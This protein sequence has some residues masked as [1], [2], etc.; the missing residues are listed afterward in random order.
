MGRVSRTDLTKLHAENEG[1]FR[2]SDCFFIRQI[3]FYFT[4]DEN[5]KIEILSSFSHEFFSLNLSETLVN[6]FSDKSAS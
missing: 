6:Y 2:T 4:M 5:H 3:H 1:A